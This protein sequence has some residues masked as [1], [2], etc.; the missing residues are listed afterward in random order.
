VDATKQDNG[1]EVEYLLNKYPKLKEFLENGPETKAFSMI[2]EWLTP[3]NV[4]VINYGDEPDMVLTGIVLHDT[5]RLATQAYLD[6]EAICLEVNRPQS[7]SFDS[8][9]QMQ[10]AVSRFKGV[11]GLCLYYNEGQNILKCKGDWY[12]NAHRFKSDIAS[13]EKIVDLWFSMDRPSYQSFI[14]FITNTYDFELA[15]QCRGNVSRI[16]ESW[17]EVLEIENAMKQKVETLRGM[18]RKDQATIVLQAY[19]QTNR[20]SFVFQLLDSKQWN[21]DA[22]KKL[23]Y[24]CLKK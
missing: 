20:A 10:E 4:I 6:I 11:E 3:T 5:Y 8:M 17:K 13:L 21:N 9:E 19:G 24:Q 1:Y 15:Q 23:L 14:E 2:F 7:Y 22:Y 12:L 18:S 16:C